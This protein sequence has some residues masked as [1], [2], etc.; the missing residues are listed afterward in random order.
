MEDIFD[1]LT[2]L[3]Q[4]WLQFGGEN[5]RLSDKPGLPQDGSTLSAAITHQGTNLAWLQGDPP[6]DK[7]ELG[8]ALLQSWADLLGVVYGE[9]QMVQG[10]TDKLI[11]A[12]NRLSFLHQVTE[13]MRT[14]IDPLQL[15]LEALR[16]AMDA[17]EAENGF[18]AQVRAEKLVFNWVNPGYN[19]SDTWRLVT[20]L[21]N[22]DRILVRQGPACRNTFPGLSNLRSFMGQKLG[23]VVGPPSYLGLINQLSRAGFDSGDIQLFES[24]VEQITAVIDVEALH[25]QQIKVEQLNRDLEIAAEVQT[26]FLPAALPDLPG[27]E[28]AATLLSASKVSGDFYDV[29]QDDNH[30]RILI[31]D[32]V[33]KGISAALLAANVRARIRAHLQQS[34]DPGRALQQANIDLY[35]DLTHTGRFVTAKL[36]YLAPNT[37]TI[38]YA[39]AGHTTSFLI[40]ANPL[41]VQH[42]PSLTLPLGILPDIED[43][44][45]PVDMG[46]ND[47]LVI[48]TDG[49]TEVENERGKLLG[50]SEITGVLLATHA[51]PAPFILESLV[52]VNREHRGQAP[53]GDDL[54]L[55]VIKKT[56]NSPP[57]RC[58]T[59]WRWPSDLRMIREIQTELLKF[60]PHLPPTDEA[61]MWLME[62]ELALTEAVSNIIKHA[63]ARHTGYIHGLI[64]L[65]PDR[66]QIDL[67][68]MGQVYQ[69]TGQ[70]ILD[71]DLETPPEGGY[72]IH[73]IHQVMDTINY[74]RF[75]DGY[76]H[77]QF[78]RSLP[79]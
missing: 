59:Y 77:W 58:L 10:L 37:S 8:R 68:D 30:I 55:L 61:N 41:R 3:H 22:R 46:P 4:A 35:E 69:P 20:A 32:V 72:G 36:I 78:S 47:V 2:K 40:Q 11:M 66:L 19:R 45:A 29:C 76:N 12:W 67:I 26:N 13:L 31:C 27:Y 1:L 57:A 38:R 42:L 17:I 48:Y 6:A 52:K 44:S 64:A 71:F 62:V 9:R 60:Q 16:F 50:L 49:L 74:H 14:N 65:Y 28:F 70:P 24:L 33:G 23:I 75:E 73:I 63:Y 39:S 54:T 15:S 21:Q 18:V 25:A 53:V 7:L 43:I 34:A 51:A 5:L 79:A 56:S